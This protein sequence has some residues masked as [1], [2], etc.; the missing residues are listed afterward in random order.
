MH[1][2]VPLALPQPWPFIVTTYEQATRH[3]EQE[4]GRLFREWR[5]PMPD[6]LVART[7]RPSGTTDL[8]SA[9]RNNTDGG[10][11]G[12]RKA[13]TPA[14]VRQVLDVVRRFGLDFYTDDPQPD[15]ARLSGPSPI[16]DR[17]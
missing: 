8:G 11:A 7:A 14:Q 13:L 3:P 4:F 6:D 5:L 16:R 17:L 1:T 9:M 2:Y 15:A 12:W 10:E